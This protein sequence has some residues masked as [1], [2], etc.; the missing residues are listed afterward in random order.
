MR[1][2]FQGLVLE[3]REQENQLRKEKWKHET[4]VEGLLSR[5]DDDM[6]KKQTEY[7]EI[8]AMY[9]EELKQLAELEEKFKPLE[10]EY[11]KVT[12]ILFN[13]WSQSLSIINL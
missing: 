12:M 4:N 11:N 8:E 1:Q 13:C 3:H 6:I 7:D 9:E 2:Q 10:E 5:Y